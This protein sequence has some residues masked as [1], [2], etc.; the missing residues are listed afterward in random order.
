[1]RIFM[2]A[3]G[4]VILSATVVSLAKKHLTEAFCIVWGI[5]AVMFICAGIILRPTQWKIYISWGGLLLVL[6]GVV[7]VLAAAFLFSVRISVLTR[8]VKE[9]AIQVSLLNQENEM[10]LR[11]FLGDTAESEMA[12][13][14]E[15]PVRH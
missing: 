13:R 12:R 5:I 10:I 11:E 8:Q 3:A 7:L 6:L 15:A 2:I 14:E 4:L 9:L 1:M